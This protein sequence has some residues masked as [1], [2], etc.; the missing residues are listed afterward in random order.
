MNKNGGLVGVR[1]Y[2]IGKYRKVMVIG[3]RK[4]DEINRKKG[5]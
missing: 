5:R 3:S 1:V 4:P 2:G